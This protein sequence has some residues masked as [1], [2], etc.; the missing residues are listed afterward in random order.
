[1]KDLLVLPS[2]MSLPTELWALILDHIEHL[3]A[4][5][6][7]AMS[8]C[9]RFLNHKLRPRLFHTVTLSTARSLAAFDR[10]VKSEQS[11][12]GMLAAR[13][14]RR[15]EQRGLSV[16]IRQIPTLHLI[17]NLAIPLHYH[18]KDNLTAV[19]RFSAARNILAA[20]P[21]IDTVFLDF[22]SSSVVELLVQNPKVTRLFFVMESPTERPILLQRENV[23]QNLTHLWVHDLTSCCNAARS[24]SGV[25]LEAFPA[26]THVVAGI[27]PSMIAHI[28]MV[29]AGVSE[30]L[31]FSRLKRFLFL[32]P[33]G[34]GS[35]TSVEKMPIW[36]SLA[37]LHDHRVHVM[38]VSIPSGKEWVF[39]STLQWN[40]LTS[41]CDTDVTWESGVPV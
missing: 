11:Q 1:M 16:M 21:N 41:E 39:S 13:V 35:T 4:C 25:T 10:F 26:L 40:R 29:T 3:P 32:I 23:Y 22:D 7:A 24:G 33:V 31:R 36:H 5:D 34:G 9:S 8:R 14:L 20:C 27:Y 6:L 15:K 12:W 19:G 30:I 37:A 18:M 38:A 28:A 2:S 17:R